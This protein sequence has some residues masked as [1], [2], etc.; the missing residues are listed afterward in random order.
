M[1]GGTRPKSLPPPPF[2][3]NLATLR[4]LLTSVPDLASLSTIEPNL[5]PASSVWCHLDMQPQNVAVEEKEGWK[6]ERDEEG[7]VPDGGEVRD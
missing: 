5:H 7:N 1:R 2:Q 4:S 3:E 6:D